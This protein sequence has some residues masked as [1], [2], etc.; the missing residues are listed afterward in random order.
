M[1]S[2]LTLAMPQSSF[3]GFAL[4]P[5]RERVITYVFID[6]AAAIVQVR[7]RRQVNQIGSAQ[8]S[9]ASI[10]RSQIGCTHYNRQLC[11]VAA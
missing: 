1:D 11:A 5:F 9:I 2:T 10:L 3:S 6:A 8:S 4:T 7:K